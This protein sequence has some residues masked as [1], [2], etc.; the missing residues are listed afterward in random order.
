MKQSIKIS[1][2]K[3]NSGYYL[4]KANGT[5]VG[6]F[7]IVTP[8]SSLFDGWRVELTLEDYIERDFKSKSNAKLWIE[9]VIGKYLTWRN[10]LT[11]EKIKKAHT[12]YLKAINE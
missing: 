9:R 10:L 4:I 6:R 8:A 1:Y 3:A 7:Y 11:S 2:H 5:V 12:N